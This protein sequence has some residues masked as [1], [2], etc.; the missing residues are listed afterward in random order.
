METKKIIDLKVGDKLIR[1]T[2]E[3]CE[4]K[5]FHIKDSND[6][7]KN[8]ILVEFNGFVVPRRYLKNHFKYENDR[9]ILE[10]E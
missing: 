1:N 9:L 10:E 5:K 4:I 6:E 3:V 7:E 2:N 8:T